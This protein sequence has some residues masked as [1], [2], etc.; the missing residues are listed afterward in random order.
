MIGVK[1]TALAWGERTKE[2][3]HY[4]NYAMFGLLMGAGYSSGIGAI[5]YPLVAANTFFMRDMIKKV[6]IDNR[7][8]CN[9][10]FV[11]NRVYGFMILLSIILG[12]IQLSV[13]N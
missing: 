9:N 4:L 13:T 11:R 6:D 7:E 8:S 5:Y 2:I 12:K 10:F 3:S 1:S